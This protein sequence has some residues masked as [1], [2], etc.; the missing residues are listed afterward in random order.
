M[1]VL[2]HQKK[3]IQKISKLIPYIILVFCGTLFYSFELLPDFDKEYH[4]AE[5]EFL[6][7]KKQ[8]TLALKEV[9][10]YAEGSLAYNRYSKVNKKKNLAYEKFNKIRKEQVVFGFDS[11][12]I[13]FERFG[14]ILSIFLYALYNLVKSFRNER[15][16]IGNR[17]LHTFIISVT[18]FYFF[19]IFQQFQDFSKATYYFMTFA[20]AGIVTLAVYLI[21][22]YQ[23]DTISHLKKKLFLV[24]KT[25]LLNTHTDKKEEM[26]SL[27]KK[28]A[29]NK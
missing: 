22:K 5:K 2:D 20:S 8:N 10:K 26:H 4:I 12:K 18:F 21:S 17:L 11:L 1:S 25:A 15:N 3:T 29:E 6:N 23:K 14:F 19:W 13:F 28:I 16:N 9:K 7:L 24:A 27:L